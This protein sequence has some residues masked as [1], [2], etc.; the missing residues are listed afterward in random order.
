MKSYWVINSCSNASDPAFNPTNP[1]AFC[2]LAS[3]VLIFGS[4]IFQ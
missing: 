4:L 1:L 2:I 3:A